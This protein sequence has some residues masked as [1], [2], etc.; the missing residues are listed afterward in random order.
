M[1]LIAITVSSLTS[2]TEDAEDAASSSISIYRS[3]I[4]L[5]DCYQQLR[6]HMKRTPL[7]DAKLHNAPF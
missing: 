2:S 1:A 6:M 7:R 4:M 3:I 5:M